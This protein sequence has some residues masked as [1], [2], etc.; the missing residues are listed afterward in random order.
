MPREKQV[1][2]CAD[3]GQTKALFDVKNRICGSCAG[4]KG[5]GRP[6]ALPLKEPAQIPPK[7]PEK[8]I[9]DSNPE[10]PG[11]VREP[12]GPEEKY[13]CEACDRPLR[14]GQRKCSCGI[15]PD[16]RGTAVEQ[17]P[18]M[19]VCPECGAVCGHAGTVAVCPHCNYGGNE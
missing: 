7:T 6:K 16:W 11:P 8:P 5:G 14:Y 3:C 4:K 2:V 18:D 9:S 10:P 17:D 12:A 19:V 15:W 1:G 13:L